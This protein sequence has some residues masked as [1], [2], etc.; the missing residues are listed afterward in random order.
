MNKITIKNNSIYITNNSKAYNG[1]IHS[2]TYVTWDSLPP[3]YLRVSAKIK[4]S[5]YENIPDRVDYQ[6]EGLY[7]RVW[8]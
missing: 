3:E 7:D 6:P 1:V 8:I 5:K 4:L 2:K